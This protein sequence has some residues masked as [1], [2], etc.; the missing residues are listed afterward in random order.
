MATLNIFKNF[1]IQ[2]LVLFLSWQVSAIGFNVNISAITHSNQATTNDQTYSASGGTTIINYAIGDRPRQLTDDEGLATLFLVHRNAV[3]RVLSGDWTTDLPLEKPYT[4]IFKS[5]V[6]LENTYRQAAQAS[7]SSAHT[8]MADRIRAVADNLRS[9][10]P[11][12][13]IDLQD[14]GL[15]SLI[16]DSLS[17]HSYHVDRGSEPATRGRLDEL[18]LVDIP[19][20]FSATM[21]PRCRDNPVLNW[22]S[23]VRGFTAS[24]PGSGAPATEESNTTVD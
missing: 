16:N 4:A 23:A 7:G 10:D 21:A 20:S 2:I 19:P 14:S 3:Q 11:I 13:V 9:K 1:T 24:V 8:A 17:T 22:R 6:M 15:E 18:F 5:L 12:K